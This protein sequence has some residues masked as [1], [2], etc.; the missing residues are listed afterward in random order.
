MTES[1]EEEFNVLG[2]KVKYKPEQNDSH[3]AKAVVELVLAEVQELRT[4]RPMLRDTDLAVLVALKMATEKWQLEEEYKNAILK[5]EGSLEKAL[6]VVS[7][8]V[9]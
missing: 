7:L 3:V 4:K 8:E 9:N 6:Q 2:C 1:Q 5:L